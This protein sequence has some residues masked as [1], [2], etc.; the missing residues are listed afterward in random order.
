[1]IRQMREM[2]LNGELGKI[3]KID[4]QYYQGWINPIIH[5]K[6]KRVYYMAIKSRKI[7]ELVVV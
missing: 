4:A 1:M 6:E 7:R 2:I 3:Q 5:N